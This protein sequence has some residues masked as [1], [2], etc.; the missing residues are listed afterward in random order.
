MN[1]QQ[2]PSKLTR[3][4]VDHG[5]KSYFIM[6]PQN[7]L[8][9]IKEILQ[10]H[11]YSFPPNKVYNTPMTIIDIGANVGVYAIY[12]KLLREDNVVHCFEPTPT[13]I[14]LLQE[15]LKQFSGISIHPYGLSNRDCEATLNINKYNTGGNSVKYGKEDFETVRVQLYNTSKIF[16]K[17]KL[18][19]IDALKVDTEGCEL[20]ILESLKDRFDDIDHIIVEYHSE[21]D[22][23]Q[24]DKLLQKFSLYGSHV[25]TIDCGV[26]KYQNNRLN[27]IPLQTS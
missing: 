5:G 21:K 15:N 17:L 11:E 13:S 7:E 6:I 12:A 18:Q 10:D 3:Y 14:E 4:Q 19:H 8:F 1:K 24:I 23:R 27:R 25:I 2:H 9:R 22:R 20:E 16:D 26:M